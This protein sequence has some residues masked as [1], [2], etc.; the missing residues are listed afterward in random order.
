MK[1]CRKYMWLHII[2]FIILGHFIAFEMYKANNPAESPT[3]D[4]DKIPKKIKFLFMNND[5]T[6]RAVVH[7][8][9]HAPSLLTESQKTTFMGHYYAICCRNNMSWIKLDDC[10][11]NSEKIDPKTSINPSIILYSL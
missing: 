10:K 7:F 3:I 9:A 6:L 1:I 4:L 8:Q 5:Y 2:N 11:S